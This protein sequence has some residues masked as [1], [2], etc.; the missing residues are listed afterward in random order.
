MSRSFDATLTLELRRSPAV[1]GAL[2]AMH[3]GALAIVWIVPAGAITRAVL[4]LFVAGSAWYA[5]SHVG[6]FG[7][8]AERWP[9]WLRPRIVTAI[10]WD[11]DGNWSLRDSESEQWRPCELREHWLH[12]WLVILRLRPETNSRALNVLIPADAVAA[13][14]FRRVR[15]R[16]RLQTAAA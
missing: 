2:C 14:A 15:A 16:L 1:I 11:S 3:A 10:E 12:P 7:R 5:L 8:I 6:C 4:T 13:D 9:G